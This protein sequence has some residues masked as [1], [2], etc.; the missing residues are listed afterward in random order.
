MKLAVIGLGLI[1]GSMALDLKEKGF[2]SYIY[3][4]DQNE[5]NAKEA[6][7]LNLVD[8]VT[9]FTNA[10]QNADLIILAVP[11]GAIVKILPEVLSLI[12]D[13]AIVTDVGSTKG[14]IA[15]SIKD[16]PKRKNFVPSHPMAGTEFSGPQA[17]L[18]GLF[19]GK[20]AVICDEEDDLPEN[21]ELI[22]KMYEALEMRVIFMNSK[23]HD[24]HAAYVSHLSHIS[25]F[26]L[27][28]TVLDKR[29]DVDAIFNLASAGFESTVRLAKSS[30]EMWT[31]IFEQNHSFIVEA[32]GAYIKRLNLFH[33]SLVNKDFDQTK[34]YMERSNEIR[35]V[36]ER[37]QNPQTGR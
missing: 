27:A 13:H 3:G 30:P 15:E 20:A 32:L 17:A 8:E 18:K 29:K 33:E 2:V 21:V 16:H 31:P 4:A 26:V 28:N 23:D 10:C 11:V 25:S 24:L 37:I 19:K 1:G 36:L 9:S 7:A 14:Q 12:K 22:K 5:E 34:K 6:K 35:Q